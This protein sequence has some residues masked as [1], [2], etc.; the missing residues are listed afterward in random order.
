MNNCWYIWYLTTYKFKIEVF[1]D[2]FK[3]YTLFFNTNFNP[4][5]SENKT[6]YVIDLYFYKIFSIRS[7]EH[8]LISVHYK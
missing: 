3:V 7:S 2:V 5:N 8:V 1:V 4:L 6:I